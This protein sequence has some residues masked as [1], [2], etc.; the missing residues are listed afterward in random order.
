MGAMLIDVNVLV[1]ILVAYL[2]FLP[3][4]LIWSWKRTITLV[5]NWPLV[6]MLPGL[7]SKLSDIHEYATQVLKQNGGT[8][9]FKGPWLANMDFLVTCDPMNVRYI[10][11][12]NFANYTKGPESKKLAEPFGDGVLNSDSESWKSYRKLIHSII[13]HRKF[14]LFQERSMRQKVSQGLIPVLEHVSRQGIV[15]DLQ[16]VFQRFTF[17]NI[18][19]LVMGFDP[20]CLTIELPEDDYRMAFDEVEEAIFYRHIVPESIWKLQKWLNIGEENKLRRAM[21][22]LDPF[23]YQCISLKK[24]EFLRCRTSQMEQVEDGKD[25]DFDIL[26]AC[27]VEQ[28]REE[29]K[30]EVAQT[31]DYRRSDKYLRDIA[32]NFIA[33]GKDTVNASLTWLFWLIATH[34]SVEEKILEEIKENLQAKEDGKWRLFSIEEQS[35]LVYLHAAICEALRLYPSLPFNHRFSVEPDVLP[36]GHCVNANTKILVSLYSMRSMEGIWGEDFLEFKPERWIS[37]IGGIVRI[38]SYK[39]IAFNTGPRSCLGRDLTFF[40]M[41][42]IVPAILWNYRIQVVEG[43]PISPCLSVMLHMKHGLKVRVS[44]RS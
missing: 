38:P 5:T 25:E 7:L 2:C 11:T 29:A 37:E 27:M 16:D 10:S 19:L 35:K 1:Q 40:Q 15:V 12:Q 21:E 8:F 18:C 4:Y 3:L 13:K 22:I 31:D 39:F 23:L 24:G 32:F 42:T 14:Q 20:K 30:G 17:D 28:E 43:H 34:P 36:S 41:K 26:T 44:K 9:R 6:G 33:A